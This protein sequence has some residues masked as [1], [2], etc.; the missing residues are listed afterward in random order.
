[1]ETLNIPGLLKKDTDIVFL[2][3]LFETIF[4]ISQPLLV[5]SLTSAFLGFPVLPALTTCHNYQ[6]T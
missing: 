4:M 6:L 2:I 3:S 1:M 5:N